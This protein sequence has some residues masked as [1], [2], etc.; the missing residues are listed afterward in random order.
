MGL[1]AE[2]GLLVGRFVDFERQILSGVHA[3]RL[4]STY[5]DG[6][7][8]SL[9]WAVQILALSSKQPQPGSWKLP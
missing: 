4:P 7:L 9:Q 8:S 6:A 2:V 5:A 3:A 1:T